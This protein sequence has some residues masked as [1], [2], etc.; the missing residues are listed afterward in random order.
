M[1]QL[2]LIELESN[3]KEEING[4]LKV[5]DLNNK[6]SKDYNIKKIKIICD[7]TP[8]D[9]IECSGVT[10]KLSE[11]HVQYHMELTASDE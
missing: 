4:V 9:T 3:E 11:E 6:N 5:I 1:K 10:I 2:Y 7:K 8:A